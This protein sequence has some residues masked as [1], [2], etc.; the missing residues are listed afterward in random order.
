MSILLVSRKFLSF[1]ANN[2]AVRSYDGF[3]KS[4]NNAWLV[5]CGDFLILFSAF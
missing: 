1:L 5:K 3:E 2:G 4:I